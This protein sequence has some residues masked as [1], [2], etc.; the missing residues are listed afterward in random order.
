MKKI[1]ATILII[2]LML[3]DIQ[4]AVAF[5]PNPQALKD[6]KSEEISIADQL[7]LRYDTIDLNSLTKI[8]VLVNRITNRVEYVFN[9]GYKRYIRPKFVMPD[10]QALY[11]KTH[12]GRNE[13]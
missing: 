2:L 13:D 1:I 12:A 9:N 7:Y 4:M 3:A 6:S 5:M 10:A 8:K 11:D